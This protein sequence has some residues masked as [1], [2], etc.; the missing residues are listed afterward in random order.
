M[1]AGLHDLTDP[2]I[3]NGEGGMSY[4]KIVNSSRLVSVA[5]HDV[6]V[7]AWNTGVP[8]GFDIGG[9]HLR[10]GS[11]NSVFVTGFAG[12]HGEIIDVENVGDLDGNGWTFDEFER[13][14][15]TPPTP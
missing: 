4:D 14:G 5:E 2:N 3:N 13:S 1:H 8:F 10:P 15:R 9:W 7:V 11:D 12:G 6:F